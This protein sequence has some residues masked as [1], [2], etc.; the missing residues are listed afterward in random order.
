[1]TGNERIA[2]MNIR[3]AI[4]WIVG[5][6]YNSY[7]D[8]YDEDVPKSKQSIIEEVYDA[9]M[10]DAYGYEQVHYGRAPREMRFAGKDFIMNYI[11][12]KIN[13]DEDVAELAEHYKWTN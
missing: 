13:E 12:K 5:G 3:G 4:N 11:T 1:M 9:A 8:G 2:A 10:S 6:Y 7:Q